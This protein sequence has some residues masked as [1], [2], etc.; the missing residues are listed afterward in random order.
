MAI[1]PPYGCTLFLLNINGLCLDN[2]LG[3]CTVKLK[4]NDIELNRKKQV[5]SKNTII[6]S[7]LYINI[8]CKVH[9]LPS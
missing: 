5:K 8:L 4:H 7:K 3:F 6:I 1:L 9:N 2:T